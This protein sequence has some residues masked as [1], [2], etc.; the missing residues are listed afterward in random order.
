MAGLGSV[1][2]CVVYAGGRVVVGYI[3]AWVTRLTK[4]RR[5][6]LDIELVPPLHI[7][8]KPPQIWA[9]GLQYRARHR[10][11]DPQNVRSSDAKC[12][13]STSDH[14]SS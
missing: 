12:I 7:I 1:C 11:E 4:S 2:D 3:V 9:T 8:V 14:I 13:Y 5:D 6:W 10:D